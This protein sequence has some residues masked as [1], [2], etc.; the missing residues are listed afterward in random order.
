MCAP[1]TCLP[2]KNRTPAI[3]KNRLALRAR[4]VCYAHMFAPPII[5]RCPLLAPP[6][7]KSWCRHCLQVMWWIHRQT[8]RHIRVHTDTFI[9]TYTS[10]RTFTNT[11]K[12]TH[13]HIHTYTIAN[14]NLTEAICKDK[15]HTRTHA[16]A[17]VH[18]HTMHTHTHI[19]V[20]HLSEAFGPFPFSISLSVSERVRL[21]SAAVLS[22]FRADGEIQVWDY[23][24]LLTQTHLRQPALH[25]CHHHASEPRATKSHT[26]LSRLRSY[27]V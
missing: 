16:R 20:L 26:L 21:I 19:S 14:F 25:V 2:K 23:L 4:Y 6:L 9:H 22:V 10:T 18:T 3:Q 8:D 24:W 7:F 27:A 15:T 13:T 1:R 11:H 17:R 5:N 12:Y